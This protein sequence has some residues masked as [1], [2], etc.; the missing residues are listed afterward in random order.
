MAPWEPRERTQMLG[1]SKEW[2]L[3]PKLSP[4]SCQRQE[5]AEGSSG[6]KIV[7]SYTARHLL[8]SAIPS[9]CDFGQVTWSLRDPWF[10]GVASSSHFC[11]SGP[12]LTNSSRDGARSAPNFLALLE[13]E[14]QKL[15]LEAA[16][17][18]GWSLALSPSAE[19]DQ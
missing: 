7:D 5:Q 15:Q 18:P 4:G 2:L 1:V 19:L 3:E 11:D 9:F 10:N 6:L 16:A 12:F 8:G 13:M 14:P 17:L